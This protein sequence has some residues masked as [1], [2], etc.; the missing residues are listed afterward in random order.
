[1]DPEGA[2]LLTCSMLYYNASGKP[3]LPPVH[4]YSSIR[5][6]AHR[7]GGPLRWQYGGS[8]GSM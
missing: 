3:R 6:S 2:G 8:D 1:M 4:R 5:S 7:A